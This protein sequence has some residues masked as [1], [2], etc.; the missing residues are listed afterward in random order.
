MPD[1]GGLRRV[2]N[3]Y[4]LLFQSVLLPHLVLH[5]FESV[6]SFEKSQLGNSQNGKFQHSQR[7]SGPNAGRRS[8]DY[9]A[10]FGLAIVG[11]Q[12]CIEQ[13]ALSHVCAS[14]QID[15]SVVAP[16]FVEIRD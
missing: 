3:Q 12:K 4:L 1:K 15:I 13:S 16:D 5:V 8:L 2:S 9:V 10:R 7:C 11:P 6:H 14:H